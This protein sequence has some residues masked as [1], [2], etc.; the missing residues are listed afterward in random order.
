M[1]DVTGVVLLDKPEGISSFGALSPLK[2][3]S[4]TRRVGHTGTLDP[5]ASGLIVALV[6]SLTRL[7]PLFT[8]MDKE[9]TA[10]F[11][12]GT[13]TDSGDPTGRPVR[14]S[15]PPT[16]ARIEAEIPAFSGTYEQEPPAHSAIHING[17]RAYELARQG[18]AVSVPLRTVTVS[19]FE[20]LE[21]KAP[22]LR[23]RIRC[24]SGTYI[25][26]IARD[27]GRAC[28]SA[29]H[30]AALRRTGVGRFSL[31]HP[32]VC[33][34]STFDPQENIVSAREELGLLDKVDIVDVGKDTEALVAVGTPPSRLPLFAK[35]AGTGERQDQ[36][37]AL[38]GSDGDLCAVVDVERDGPRYRFVVPRKA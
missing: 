22:Q 1:G 21:W 25:R 34:P 15:D 9:Y 38:F 26:S 27:L 28:D 33:T 17:R 14:S 29:A 6:G 30:V 11:D 4:G 2:R 8:R 3:T 31:G 20:I 5:F 18:T 36:T 37:V 7:A 13:E 24:S 23:V 19:A 32:A 10:T 35:G 16:P 12:F